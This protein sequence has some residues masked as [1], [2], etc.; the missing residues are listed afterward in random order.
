MSASP[1]PAPVPS[2]EDLAKV[3]ELL[4]GTPYLY[5]P[6]GPGATKSFTQAAL[7]AAA[8][9]RAAK[10]AQ[11]TQADLAASGAE[12]EEEALIPIT[13]TAMEEGDD[14]AD[15]ALPLWHWQV[16]NIAWALHNRRERFR[17][18]GNSV[19][20]D[21]LFMATTDAARA[22]M[23]LLAARLRLDDTHVDELTTAL[24]EAE[25]ML[26]SACAHTAHLPSWIRKR[27]SLG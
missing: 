17:L 20:A 11:K 24:A 13:I 26:T 1:R 6:Q 9:A 21:P 23:I 8:F 10:A 14:Q 5:T 18:V 3:V 22:L 4:G 25:E 19:D 7:A 15:A 12:P 2:I 27:G 16:T